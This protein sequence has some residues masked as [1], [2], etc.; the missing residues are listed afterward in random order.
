ME[1]I[2]RLAQPKGQRL[3]SASHVRSNVSENLTA[4]ELFGT[5][6]EI[7]P[8]R[9][10]TSHAEPSKGA[11]EDRRFHQLVNSFSD[12]HPRAPSHLPTVQSI[13]QANPS[14]QSERAQ[15]LANRRL[16]LSRSMNRPARIPQFYSKTQTHLIDIGA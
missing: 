4:R 15:R 12:V 1:R 16:L 2:N 14:L 3:L 8:Q 13:V 9:P 7:P 5:L 10:R 11:S 6:D